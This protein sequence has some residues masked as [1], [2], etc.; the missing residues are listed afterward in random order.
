MTREQKIAILME[1]KCTMQEA[2]NY[3]DKNNAAIFTASELLEEV[4]YWKLE[5]E[6]PEACEA[7]Y[8]NMINNKKPLPDWGIVDY[9]G[10]TYYI[11]YIL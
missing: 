5:D 11:G 6:D 4:K 3:V 2:K 10:T 7:E 9:E 8:L 1:D